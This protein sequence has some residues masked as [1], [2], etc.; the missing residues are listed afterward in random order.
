M[1]KIGKFNRL[2]VTR[3]SEHGVYVSDKEHSSEILLPTRYCNPMPEIGDK[4][5]LFVYKDSE[6][7]LIATTEK[8]FVQVD[9]F[10]FLQVCDV[11]RIG[12][13][14]DWGLPKNLLCPYREQKVRMKQG[15]IYPVY[16]FLDHATMRIVA[17]AKIE[18]YLG[19][20]IPEYKRGNKVSC[21]V[22]EHTP[23]GY[24]VIVDNLHKGII[25]HNELFRLLEIGQT[26]D[27]Y[28][29]N[30]RSDNK[31]DLT[32]TA[33]STIGRVMSLESSILRLLKDGK[34]TL[35]DKSSP[36]EIK[37]LLQCSKRDFKKVVGALYRNH[38]IVISPDGII[39]LSSE[40]E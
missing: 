32:L 18:K 24:K 40:K 12:V 38:E 21:L 17:T 39:S 29:K 30:I 3:A 13:F 25:Y 16:V 28:V 5:Y 1:I 14:L 11:S 23:I 35:T 15:G 22:L 19:N 31:I 20:V 36:E 6:D 10:A 26:I 33:P 37:N 27:A 7:R 2:T 34:F 4:L 9:E 8:P